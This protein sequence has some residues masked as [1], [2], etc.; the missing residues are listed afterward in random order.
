MSQDDLKK[1]TVKV[2]EG[3]GCLFQPMTDEYTYIL[4][5][6]HLFSEKIVN[7][8][9]Q[10]ES[11]QFSDGTEIII[12]KQIPNGDFWA[13]EPIPFILTEGETYFP[14]KK[15]D[16]AILKIESQSGFDSIHI[17]YSFEEEKDIKLCGFPERLA[18]ENQK[19]TSHSVESFLAAS[20][21]CHHAQLFGGLIHKNINGMSGGGLL[22]IGENGVFIIG[23]QSEMAIEDL[24][25]GQIGFVP[26]KYFK[27]IINYNEYKGLLVELLPAYFK[28]FSFLKDEIF[29]IKFGIK[30]KN[31]VEKMLE[32]LQVHAIQ[33]QNSDI[34]PIFIKN[35]L[36]VNLPSIYKH[37]RKEIR[38][39]KV[40]C[41][42]L[43]LLTILNILKQCSHC[44]AEIPE[45]LK[46]VRL[47][48]S[49]ID[50]DFWL[51]HIN[52]LNKI[53]Y[54]GLEVN[55][56]VIVASNIPAQ[57]DTHFTPSKN[58]VD[59]ISIISGLRN[60]FNL[61]I[62]SQKIDCATDFPFDKYKF[63][64]ISAFKEGI[65]SKIDEGFENEDVNARIKILE[66]LYEQLFS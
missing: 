33:I 62:I 35:Y 21:Y 41:L 25:M 48:Y 18:G 51:K 1:Y 14:H 40:W 53:D 10:S 19:Y 42:W 45:I 32:V 11:V 16:I 28:S 63:V 54:H 26:I 46:K 59:N 27:E 31:K 5:A 56:T 2:G 65:V 12:N 52:E 50:E 13:K 30:T 29:K 55:G 47:I 15:A 39:K 34:T 57:D 64:N 24:S 8:R 49:N 23:I 61:G 9:G 6:K 44:S 58:I 17:Q 4:T 20:D 66:K 36:K 7:D 37:G 22:K 60:D 3:S 43:E 38:N